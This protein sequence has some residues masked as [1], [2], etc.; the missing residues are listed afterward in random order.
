MNR[1][2]L[3]GMLLLLAL[4]G[5]AQ[6]P[7]P[8]VSALAPTDAATAAPK[9][10]AT[11]PAAPS[12]DPV[13]FAQVQANLRALGYAA[14]K[15]NDP[16]DPAFQRALVNFQRDQGLAEDGRLS[17]QVIEKLRVMRAA[18]RMAPAAPP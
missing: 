7:K 8:A 5:C 14:G 12:V 10:L 13:T 11:A 2:R 15:A 17:A 6:P 4:S 3:S 16:A 9:V 1:N 18:L